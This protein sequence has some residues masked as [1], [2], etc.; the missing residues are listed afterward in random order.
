MYISNNLN[1]Y[2]LTKYLNT[3]Q[4]KNVIKKRTLDFTLNLNFETLTQM[5]YPPLKIIKT[6]DKTSPTDS[7]FR[8]N[9]C[10]S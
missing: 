9:E 6:T 7:T 4:Y 5:W 1:P 3:K 8:K 2:K 10:N